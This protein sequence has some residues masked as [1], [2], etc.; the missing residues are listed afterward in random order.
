MRPVALLVMVLAFAPAARAA[1]RA[2]EPPALAKARTLYNAGDF[3]GAIDAAAE[4][5]HLPQAADAAALVMARAHLERY[6]QRAEPADLAAAREALGAVHN[7]A[8]TARDQLDLL[9]G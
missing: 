9:V 2:V 3:Q 5:R 8:L 6:R 1:E 7:G 4:A